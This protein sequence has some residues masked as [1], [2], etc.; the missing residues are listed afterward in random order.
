MAAVEAK[1]ENALRLVRDASDPA[2]ASLKKRRDDL[3][4]RY[5]DA[6]KQNYP[7]FEDRLSNVMITKTPA[8]DPNKRLDDV[9]QKLDRV[10]Q[11]LEA[12]RREKSAP[13]A[14]PKDDMPPPKAIPKENGPGAESSRRAID[15][16]IEGLYKSGK[17]EQAVNWTYAA[18][19][20]RTPTTEELK[21]GLEKL[22]LEGDRNQLLKGYF[23]ALFKK[24]GKPSDAAID[25]N[26]RGRFWYW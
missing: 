6:L 2:V 24:N 5:A 20:G 23:E 11:E 25:N 15:K 14:G 1:L 17:V 3:R 16:S 7:G 4:S 21:E 10:L 8:S 12:I 26:I 13:T 19:Y 9:E 22:P 18:Y